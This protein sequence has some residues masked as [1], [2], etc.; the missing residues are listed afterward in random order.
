MLFRSE[1]SLG[2]TLTETE[3]DT[4]DEQIRNIRTQ[5]AEAQ[6][7]GDS[8]LANKLYSQEQAML[9]K[10]GGSNPIVGARGR[11]A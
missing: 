3:K 11:M 6:S 7:V 4:A 2:A 8:K 9:A 10:R 5:V 1:G